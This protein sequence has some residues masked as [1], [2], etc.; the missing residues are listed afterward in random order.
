MD[1]GPYASA[2]ALCIDSASYFIIFFIIHT[3]YSTSLVAFSV[4]SSTR[5]SSPVSGFERFID[6]G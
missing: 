5:A 1:T 6:S 4:P 2:E 3:S